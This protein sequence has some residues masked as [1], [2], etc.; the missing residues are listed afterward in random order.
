GTT[1]LRVYEATG[2]PA[3]AVKVTFRAKVLSVR[4]TNLMGDAGRELKPHE[5]IVQFDL[6]PFEIK[7][8][9][10]RLSPPAAD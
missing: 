6:A 8:F 10:L 4:E 2:K 3:V 1:V 5:N 7:T 9:R